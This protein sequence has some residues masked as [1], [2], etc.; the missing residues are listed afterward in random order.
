MKSMKPEAAAALIQRTD[1][2]FAAALLKRM[3]PAEAGAVM[4][5]LKP[6]LAAELI[7]MMA[8]MP[9]AAKGGRP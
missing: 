1:Q 4:D 5:R 7:A 6:D 3:K 2:P 9:S 8:T